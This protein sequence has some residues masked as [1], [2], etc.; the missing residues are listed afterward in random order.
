MRPGKRTALV[1]L[2]LLVVTSVA[3]GGGYNTFTPRE[4]TIGKRLICT[5]GCRQG[6]LVCNTLNCTVKLQ[7]QA[8]IRQ[9]ATL[10]EPVS[11]ILQSFVQEYGTEVLANP[12][13]AGFNETA[14]ITPWVVLA[15]GVFLVLFF[16]KR[17]RDRQRPVEAAAPAS[18]AMPETLAG[19]RS[20]IAAELERELAPRPHNPS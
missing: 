8:E 13:H 6:A 5:C 18:A 3:L 20:E 10:N 17:F 4:Q 15:I 9:R 7:M 2:A 1:L 16:V 14:W 19:I 12:T 11:L